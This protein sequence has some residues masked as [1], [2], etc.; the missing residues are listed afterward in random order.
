VAIHPTLPK[1]LTCGMVNSSWLM[2]TAC[3]GD[4][5]KLDKAIPYDG[6]NEFRDGKLD[7]YL[8]LSPV[9]GWHG[10]GQIGYSCDWFKDMDE[11]DSSTVRAKLDPLLHPDIADPESIAKQAFAQRSR[12]HFP[13][14]ITPPD[15][16]PDPVIIE[17]ISGGVTVKGGTPPYTILATDTEGKS[18]KIKWP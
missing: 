2:W 15:P 12:T 6:T 4:K 9:F 18:D 11:Y 8:G 7:Q 14:G 1:F 3:L 17:P 10:H 5:P 13:G 16:P